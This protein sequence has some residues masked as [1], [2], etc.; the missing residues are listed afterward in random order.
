MGRKGGQRHLKRLPAPVLWPI[1]RKEYR[2]IV[3]AR[4]GPHGMNRCLP[5]LLIV[6]DMLKLVKMRREAKFLLS[7]GHIKVDGRVRRDDD[8]PVGLMDVM[9][10]PLVKKAY[11]ILPAPKRGLILHPI[12]SEERGFKLCQLVNKTSVKGGRLQLNLHDGR[13]IVLKVADPRKPLEDVYE[14]YD[15]LKIQ[16]PEMEVSAHL[17]LEEG[18]LAVVTGGKNMGR[19]GEV[20]GI[21]K[22]KGPYSPTITL[23]DGEGN[24][25]KTVIDY[26]FAI[27]KGTPWISIPRED[28]L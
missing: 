1:H 3:K 28:V 13:N 23:K 12:T 5:L 2:W 11:R 14:T 10:I 22:K 15:T 19:Y 8:Y 25:F 20:V 16:V 27:G 17:K 4:P 18:V 24:Q 6:R 26:I 9:D 21:E 7:E